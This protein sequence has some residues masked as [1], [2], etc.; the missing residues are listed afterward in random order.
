MKKFILS[1]FVIGCF[2]L[3]AI[4]YGSGGTLIYVTTPTATTL[5]KNKTTTDTKNNA[6]FKDGEY[7][8]NSVDAYYGY[9]QVKAVIT[10]GRLTDVVFL[11]YPQDRGHSIQINNYAM[12]ILKSEAIRAQSSNVNAVS[13]ATDSSGAF[14]QSLASALAQA[15][16]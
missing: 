12:P 3:Y 6:K 15:R 1:F 2:A 16:I 14:N 5:V 9:I 11:D 4:Y 8:G 13:G 7:T 10:G